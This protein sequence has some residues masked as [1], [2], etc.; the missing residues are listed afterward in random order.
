MAELLSE[1]RAP[2]AVVAVV[3]DQRL[4][5]WRGYGRLDLASDAIPDADTLFRLQSITKPFTGLAIMQLRDAGLLDLDDPLVRHLPEFAAVQMRHGAADDVT[6]RLLLCH[7]SGLLSE[8]TK[9]PQ[10]PSRAQLLASLGHL[11]VGS[12]PGTE[13]K[14]SNVGFALLGEVIARRGGRPYRDYVR[15]E[16]LEP[17]GMASSGFEVT[18]THRA[19]LATGYEALPNQDGLAAVP[20]PPMDG[21]AAAGDLHA[22]A[23]DLARMV[24]L[25]FRLDAPIRAGAQVLRGASLAEMHRPQFLDAEWRTGY[26]LALFALR[27]GDHV[28]LGHTGSGAGYRVATFFSVPIRSGVIALTTQSTTDMRHLAMDV[29]DI[30]WDAGVDAVSDPSSPPASSAPGR[31]P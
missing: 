21:L 18:P 17:L 19:N 15:D 1:Y 10:T 30:I 4:A 27:R 12:R 5:W 20:S 11:E 2:G 13:F 6:L 14:Y 8:Q 22:S 28:Y 26:G 3:R 23:R 7:H 9:I 31:G 16:V 29:L 24:A 25:Q